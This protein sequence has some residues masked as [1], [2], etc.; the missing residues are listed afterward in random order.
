[1]VDTTFRTDYAYEKELMDAL[2]L[3]GNSL[4]KVEM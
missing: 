4:H 3:T 2:P 1:M